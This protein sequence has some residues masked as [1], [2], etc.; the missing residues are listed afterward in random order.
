MALALSALISAMIS[1]V[2]GIIVLIKP[3][4]LNIAVGLYLLI[5]GTLNLITALL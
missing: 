3:K 2:F 4:T 1:I 5:V